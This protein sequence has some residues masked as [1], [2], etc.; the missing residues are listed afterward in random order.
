MEIIATIPA[1]LGSTRLPR[2][3]LRELGG[4]PILQH[5]LQ[6]AREA[7]AFDRVLAL[8][9]DP[10]VFKEVQ[11]WGF[12]AHMT[13]PQC[14]S[15]TERV[16]SVIGEISG[17]VF[18][19]IQG[20]EPFISIDLL[21]NFVKTFHK[22]PELDLLTAIYPIK[23]ETWLRDPSRV[24][25]VL[26]TQDNALYFSRNC[27]PYLRD[28]PVSSDWA[29]AHPF[30]GHIGIYGYSRPLLERMHSFKPSILEPAE[31]LEQLKFL[32]NGVKIR[33]LKTNEPSFGIDTEDD[34]LKAEQILKQE[35][36]TL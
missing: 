28:T 23:E 36:K 18:V 16:A 17:D 15:G 20:D 31:R 27:V 3:I 2:K 11:S 7:K 24:K 5:V 14:T 6:H 9:D 10:V 21:Q 4:I 22:H 32:E 12:E 25:V 1:R 8:V 13:S 35:L 26:D 19:N 30:W 33:C 34:L 29:K